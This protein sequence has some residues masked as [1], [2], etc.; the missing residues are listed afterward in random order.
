MAKSPQ[1]IRKI[2]MLLLGAFICLMA[3]LWV[4]LSMFE[5]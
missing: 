1:Q 4:I 3:A 2:A 5:S